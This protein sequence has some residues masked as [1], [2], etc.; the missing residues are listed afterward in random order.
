MSRQENRARRSGLAGMVIVGVVTASGGCVLPGYEVTTSSGTSD[1]TASMGGGGSGDTGGTTSSHGGAGGA[2]VTTATTGTGGTDTGGSTGDPTKVQW[3]SA[4]GGPLEEDALA[5]APTPQSGEILAGGTLGSTVNFSVVTLDPL[6]PPEPSSADGYLLKLDGNGMPLQA[7]LFE[8]TMSFG[9]AQSVRGITFA[10][11]GSKAIAVCFTDT[12]DLTVPLPSE[13]YA[14]Y[15]AHDCAILKYTSGGSLQWATHL[16]DTGDLDVAGLA[17]DS[18][19]GAVIAAGTFAGMGHFAPD[20]AGGSE[21]K[22][23][24]GGTDVYVVSLAGGDGAAEWVKTFG[25]NNNDFATGFAADPAMMDGSAN[26]WVAGHLAGDVAT[27][28][29]NVSAPSYLGATDAFALGLTTVGDFQWAKTYGD[30]AWQRALGVG[31][32]PPGYLVL[33]G[34]FD[35]TIDLPAQIAN[36]GLPAVKDMFVARLSRY[37]GAVVGAEVLAD[38]SLQGR[39]LVTVDTAASPGFA[40]AGNFDSANGIDAFVHHFG[41]IDQVTYPID[42]SELFAGSGTQRIDAIAAGPSGSLFV[43]GSF[44]APMAYGGM[45]LNNPGSGSDLFVAKL[46]P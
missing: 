40:V 5:V 23:S 37:S 9:G 6:A 28:L 12:L 33:A 2:T 7:S 31:L 38:V 27:S 30:A 39:L 1:T 44:T 16:G 26:V 17:I 10:P 41:T 24:V 13:F 32:G 29:D 35:G 11:D 20:V 3:V 4:F 25:S 42:W 45:M 22:S 46:Q 36:G 21:D 18:S 19:T 34:D 8:G 15:G 14:S 43:A